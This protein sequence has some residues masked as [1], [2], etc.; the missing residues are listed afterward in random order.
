MNI[1][2]IFEGAIVD[3]IKSVVDQIPAA[4]ASLEKQPIRHH[5]TMMPQNYKPDPVSHS[6]GDPEPGRSA[7][8]QKRLRDGQQ[9]HKV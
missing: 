4:K 2:N 1:R 8:D 7:L 6:F 9:G 5:F 3:S